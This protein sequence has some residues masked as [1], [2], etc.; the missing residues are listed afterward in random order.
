MIPEKRKR[1]FSAASRWAENKRRF[2]GQ[3]PLFAVVTYI[4]IYE[5]SVDGW[6][7]C[8]A[9][10]SENNRR[11]SS[12]GNLLKMRTIKRKLSLF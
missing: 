2:V 9:I 3:R 4:Y 5:E 1:G 7:N 10:A 11:E 8:V 6:A 12:Q